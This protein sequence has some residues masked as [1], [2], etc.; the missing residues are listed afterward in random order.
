MVRPD[1]GDPAETCKEIL[2][3]LCT[4]FKEDASCHVDLSMIFLYLI[5][6][7]YIFLHVKVITTKTGHKLLPLYIRV[8]QGD[9][10]SI[11]C[12]EKTT[13]GLGVDYES[14]PKILPPACGSSQRSLLLCE[15][16]SKGP[17]RV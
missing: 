11:I 6:S 15:G 10:P 9:G 8:I 3:I 4:Q 17:E 16:S 7:Y 13:H 1:S 2:K 12:R 14:V 5:N